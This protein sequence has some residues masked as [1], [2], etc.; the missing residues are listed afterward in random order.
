MTDIEDRQDHVERMGDPQPL[1]IRKTLDEVRAYAKE[2]EASPHHEDALNFG[3]LALIELL[4]ETYTKGEPPPFTD[5]GLIE[6]MRDYLAFAFE[7]AI[8]HRGLSA[9]RSVQKFRAWLWVLGVE[10][11]TSDYPSYGVPILKRVAALLGV[12]LPPEIAAWVDG[13]PCTPDCEMG[14]KA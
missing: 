10:L 6:H 3:W 14:C 8:D 11:D 1:R 9:I 12:D 5:A 4:P 2:L 13:Q 7:K